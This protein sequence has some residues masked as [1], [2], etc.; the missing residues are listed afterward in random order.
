MP[1]ELAPHLPN[2]QGA[3]SYASEFESHC[4][5]CDLEELQRVSC[6]SAYVAWEKPFYLTECVLMPPV[7]NIT[8]FTL[9]GANSAS[10]VASSV[11]RTAP[12][13]VKG[14]A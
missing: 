5:E 6:L 14:F 11:E 1:L 4:N 13:S 10:L 7:E 12:M 9:L 8:R 2:S 3:K